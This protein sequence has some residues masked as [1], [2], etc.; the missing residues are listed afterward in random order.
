MA[1]RTQYSID[2]L[3]EQ[4]LLRQ[5]PPSKEKAVESLKT[6]DAWLN[7]AAINLQIKAIR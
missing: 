2:R 1:K 6:A 4:G 7:E 3:L 5:I